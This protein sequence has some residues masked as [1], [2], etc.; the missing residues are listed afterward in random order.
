VADGLLKIA[1]VHEFNL[2]R[3]PINFA[4]ALPHPTH[5]QKN[6]SFWFPLQQRTQ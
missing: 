4:A 1:M 3:Q 2:L 5:K 6:Y